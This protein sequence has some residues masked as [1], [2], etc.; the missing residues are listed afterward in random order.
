M[1]EGKH[2]TASNEDFDQRLRSQNAEWG[3]RCSSQIGA[4]AAERH[5]M[6]LLAREEMPANNFLLVLEKM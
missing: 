3:V 5:G 6:K 1:V 4:L 2:T